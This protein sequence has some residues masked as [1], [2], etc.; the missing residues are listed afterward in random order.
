MTPL[1]R[2][3]FVSWCPCNRGSVRHGTPQTASFEQ[4]LRIVMCLYIRWSLKWNLT[5]G[6]SGVPSP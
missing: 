5:F 2:D 4:L 3:D 1:P 6:E